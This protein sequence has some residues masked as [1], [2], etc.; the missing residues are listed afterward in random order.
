MPSSISQ[1]R[2]E[3]LAVLSDLLMKMF[4]SDE[5]RRL[6]RYLPDGE[7][8]E[9]GLP[10]ATASP[11][12]LSSELVVQLDQHGMLQDPA[13]FFDRLCQERHLRT[14]EIRAVQTMLARSEAGTVTP[15]PATP[16]PAARQAEEPIDFAV[17]TALTLETRAVLRQLGETVERVLPDT[18][19]LLEVGAIQAR[20]RRATVAVAEAGM[21][22][23]A[24]ARLAQEVYAAL[25]PRAAIFIGVAG[26]IKDVKLGDVVVGT[27]IYAY[28]SGKDGDQ[29]RP[30]PQ[31]S[32]S[33]YRL[34]QR[35]RADARKTGWFG[36]I[37][38]A[39]GEAEPEVFIG[40]IAAGERV[41]SSTRSASAR[42]IQTHYSDALAVEM[43]GYGFL[44]SLVPLKAEALV[45]RGVSDL[46]EKKA[47]SDAAGWQQRAARNAAAF[48]FEVMAN[49]DP[50]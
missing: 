44:A 32:E 37:G 24:A 14:A 45:V 49:L 7:R 34:I 9:R 22:N 43:E 2:R 5:L 42:I 15:K 21:G 18:G 8:L 23:I 27:K 38:L 50:S 46:V 6:V 20:G 25:R 11:A 31:L 12:S 16:Q 10:G 19:T 39:A 1:S 28:E 29:F 30:R 47:E 33:S 13:L 41:V 4:S 48:A 3:A 17:F 26:G 40:P 35:A 36:R